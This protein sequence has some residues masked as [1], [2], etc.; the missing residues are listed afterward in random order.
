MGRV[1][2]LFFPR[3]KK[4][5]EQSN[6]FLKKIKSNAKHLGVE[7]DGFQKVQKR[8]RNPIFFVLS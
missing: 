1:Q 3:Y 8:R 4:N 5:G 2:V 7:Q 6:D